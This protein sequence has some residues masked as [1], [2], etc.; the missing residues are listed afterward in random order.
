M[1]ALCS[2]TEQEN[3]CPVIPDH[4]GLSEYHRIEDIPVGKLPWSVRHRFALVMDIK[5]TALRDWRALADAFGFEY[6]EICYMDRRDSPTLCLLDA[7]AVKSVT[8]QELLEMLMK[9]DRKDAVMELTEKLEK[10]WLARREEAG[11]DR[12]LQEQD[13]VSENT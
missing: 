11:R 4:D 2:C 3:H 8:V 7:L 9:F 1:C 13:L 5:T 10:A 6:V 12:P